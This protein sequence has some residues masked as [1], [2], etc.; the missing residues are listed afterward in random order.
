MSYAKAAVGL[1]AV[2]WAEDSDRV[3]V[4]RGDV[5]VAAWDITVCHDYRG[6]QHVEE[7]RVLLERYAGP[8]YYAAQGGTPRG[9]VRGLCRDLLG[10]DP[11]DRELA[12]WTGMLKS[13]PKG[14]LVTTLAR[15]E[16]YRRRHPWKGSAPASP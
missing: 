10:R 8:D 7:Y 15:R 5:P 6:P 13:Q 9:F 11:S 4:R 14:L 2:G 16:E 12:Q 3:I 1:E